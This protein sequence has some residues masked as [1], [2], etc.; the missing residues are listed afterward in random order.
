MARQTKGRLFKSGKK[1][2]YHVQ[3]YVKGKQF[4]RTLKDSSGNNITDERSARKAA[5]AL[6]NPVFAAD[7]TQRL[8]NILDAVET[9]EMK[10][11][12]AEK[13]ARE[14]AQKAAE[15][16]EDKKA[17][18]IADAWNKFIDPDERLKPD[19]SAQNLKN[20]HGY[21]TKFS[22]WLTEQAEAP[23]Y[24]RD[25][26]SALVKRYAGILENTASGSTFNKYR[27]FLTSFFKKLEPFIRGTENP[28]ESIEY[29]KKV[30]SNKRRELSFAELRAVLSDAEQAGELGLLL[31]IGATTGLR[32][33]DAAT[34]SWEQIS[35]ER[36]VIQNVNR[37]TG[38]SVTVGII[39][40]LRNILLTMPE[41]RRIGYLMPQIAS[42][43]LDPRKQPHLVE[44]IQQYFRKK[45]I[46]TQREGT[47]QGTGKRAVVEVGFHSLRHSFATFCG[48]AGTAESTTQKLLGHSKMAMTLYYQHSTE[49][50]AIDA[51]NKLNNVFSG[52]LNASQVK[53]ALSLK[54]EVVALLDT[55]SESQLQ[56]ILTKY[57]PQQKNR[58]KT[59]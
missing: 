43:Y 42:E 40:I 44:R 20:Y 54:D 19:C 34:L 23:V 21:W 52:M 5:D 47:G 56:E 58:G 11:E 2:V 24:M 31:W 1:G 3:F 29:K 14:L 22:A 50:A 13:E 35:L 8:K 28:F 16:E 17:L 18:K 4:V 32:L 9:A 55:L 39:P 37:K 57:G 25:I 45:G 48:E 12:R 6:L 26:T 10:Q 49:S 53:P 7:K 51:A 46:R 59:F 27:A 36:G 41:D 15:R 30:K 38:A 33:G